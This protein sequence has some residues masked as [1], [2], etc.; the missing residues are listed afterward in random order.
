MLVRGLAR[1]TILLV[2][3]GSSTFVR[4]S[5]V[6][7]MPRLLPTPKEASYDLKSAVSIV[8]R[9][10]VRVACPAQGAAS[11]IKA[12]AASWWKADVKVT[13]WELAE[14]VTK[15]GP[16]GYVLKTD[17]E[18]VGISANTLSGVRY[19]LY[20]LRQMAE[21]RRG[22]LKL[23]G[24]ECPHGLVRDCPKMAFRALHV[25]WFPETP[26]WLIEH[27]IRQAA[28]YRFNYLILEP[29]GVFR[30]ACHPWYGWKNGAMT[31]ADNESEVFVVDFTRGK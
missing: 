2:V 30:S 14:D 17:A 20:A 24:W 10:V 9:L 12:H 19:A 11:W 4:A 22:T 16:E 28:Y 23:S 1:I 7:T 3:I 25:C 15:L 27:A 6:F 5:G 18:G 31:K 26:E 29:W 8:D 21:P 13:A